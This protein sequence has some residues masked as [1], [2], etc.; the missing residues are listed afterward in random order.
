MKIKHNMSKFAHVTKPGGSVGCEND[1]EWLQQ[2]FD[3]PYE[4]AKMWQ[5]QYKID[6]SYTIEVE[7]VIHFAIK[8]EMQSLF[9]KWW[10]KL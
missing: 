6:K 10:D 9:F 3:W 4:W 7:E 8:M 1:T 5:I 2:N